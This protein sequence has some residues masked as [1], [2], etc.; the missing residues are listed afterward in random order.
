MAGAEIAAL[1][2]LLRG[3]QGPLRAWPSEAS[4]PRGD[5]AAVVRVPG[6]LPEDIYDAQPLWSRDGKTLFVCQARLDNRAELFRSLDMNNLAH[7]ETADSTLLFAAYER[8][9]E[10]CVAHLT[11][12]FAFAAYSSERQSIFAAVD[13]FAHYRLYY[14]THGNRIVFCTQLAPL[15]DHERHAA[16]LDDVALGLSAE[17]R[18]LPGLTPYRGIRQVT[19]GE[20]LHWNARDVK[21][22][23]WWQPEA[24][25]SAR[26]QNPAEYVEAARELFDRAVTECLRSTTP[27]S[28]TL[29]GG[30]DSGLVT[31][32]AARQLREHGRTLKAYT[33]APRE[34]SSVFQRA[35]WDADDSPFSAQTAAFHPNIEH[36]VLRGDGRVALDLIADIHQ[37]SG[38]PVRNGANHLW[39]DDIARNIGPGVLLTGARGN[40][41]V[42]YTGNGGFAE[43]LRDRQWSA[44]LQCALAARRAEG[45]PLWKTFASGLL[46]TN[47]F[48]YLR[49]RVYD[50]KW[51]VLS[52]TT[53]AFRNQHTASLHP[54]RPAPHT[55]AAFLR[56]AMLPNFVWA[57]DPL[58]QWGIE[59]RD[60][61]ADRR[62]VELLFTF[63]LSA[64]AHKGQSRG[65]AR[66]LGVGLLP[67][68]IRLRRTQGQQAADYATAM[69]QQLPRYRAVATRMA[70]SA[71]CCDLFDLSLL[72]TSLNHVAAGDLSA[73]LTS[74]I[75]RC[76]DAGLMLLEQEEA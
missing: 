32:A 61:L 36:I 34:G 13:H 26:H 5:V 47:T 4:A 44:A 75:D 63:P 1:G 55:R 45:K 66:Q 17:A 70:G 73:T 10:D 69:A 11:G 65:L 8:W 72:Q 74:T 38:Q 35:R 19:G 20:C 24:R 12:D 42:S 64:F 71:A 14:A 21:T 60:P 68:A 51:Q 29:S 58:A 39:L 28:S 62:L 57:A 40:F 76:I 46:P 30:L 22:S 52:L 49:N 67:D 2:S 27:V 41:S 3:G 43:L 6:F 56:K 31:A 9:G 7:S 53:A 16:T 50:P 25:P 37:R 33:S 15:R 48:A 23:R 59:W 18:Y 54:N